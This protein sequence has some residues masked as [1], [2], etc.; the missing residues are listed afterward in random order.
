MSLHNDDRRVRTAKMLY[1]A[2]R[3]LGLGLT[4]LSLILIALELW[5]K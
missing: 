5:G 3:N 4:L 1:K 2:S